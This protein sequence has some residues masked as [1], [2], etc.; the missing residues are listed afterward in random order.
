MALLGKWHT[1]GT[2]AFSLSRGVR[3][4]TQSMRNGKSNL[5]SILC[6]TRGHVDASR[7]LAEFRSSRP[8]IIA[9][10][11]EM[12]LCLPVEGLDKDRLAAFRTL[13]APMRRW[14]CSARSHRVIRV[15]SRWRRRAA[16]IRWRR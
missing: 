6:G 10:N 13:C 12:L 7:A 8:V 5:T 2:F 1:D 15:T 4:K 3:S 9:S 16:S 11:R 14:L